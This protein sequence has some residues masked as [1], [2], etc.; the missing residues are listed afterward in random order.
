MSDQISYKLLGAELQPYLQML[1]EA[2][3][4][5]RDKAVSDFPIFV[6]HQH[7]VEVGI[8]LVK[9]DAVK[10]NWSVN[11]SSLE[12][13]VAKQIIQE[14]KMSDFQRVYKDPEAYLCMFVLSELGANFIFLPR[15]SAAD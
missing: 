13:F 11:A 2:A 3:D 5:V 12:E 15:E 1:G 14:E 8:P 7:E 10:T 6:V 9:R 4:T